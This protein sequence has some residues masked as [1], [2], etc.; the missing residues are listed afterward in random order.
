[1]GEGGARRRRRWEGG[2]ALSP[3]AAASGKVTPSQPPSRGRARVC[4][5]IPRRPGSPGEARWQ[6]AQRLKLRAKASDAA[7]GPLR[8]TAK[9]RADFDA[10]QRRS[11]VTMQIHRSLLAPP[12][13]PK[14]AP[15][16][17]SRNMSTHPSCVDVPP[18]TPVY[19][20]ASVPSEG[21]I[22]PGPCNVGF[23]LLGLRGRPPRPLF[24]TG[25]NAQKRALGVNFS[26]LPRESIARGGGCSR[27]AWCRNSISARSILPTRPSAATA[28]SPGSPAGC[29]GSRPGS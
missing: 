22:S 20:E 21:R 9:R 19:A 15:S 10:Q 24:D 1:M 13:A 11:S 29:S 16:R 18:S 26:E 14:S 5:H 27:G 12:C 17:A 23:R 8:A 3:G 6:G 4:T 7:S 25:P 2:G 28:K